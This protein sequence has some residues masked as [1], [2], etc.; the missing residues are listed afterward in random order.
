MLEAL[1]AEQAY[2]CCYCQIQV[3]EVGGKASSIEHMEPQS[4]GGG[5]GVSYVN[6]AASCQ[7]PRRC[8]NARQDRALALLPHDPRCDLALRL[9]EDG[10]LVPCPH[11]GLS[12]RELEDTLG[13]LGLNR[14][15]AL[16]EARRSALQALL[17][18]DAGLSLL[19]APDELQAL[20]DSLLHPRQLSAGDTRSALPS[21]AGHLHRVLRELSAC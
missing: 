15:K 9:E 5:L 11:S 1:L 17:G 2:L 18:E 20:L 12:R 21:F 14:D 10:T 19:K 4:A 8:N 6:M 3:T 7:T 13:I 16:V